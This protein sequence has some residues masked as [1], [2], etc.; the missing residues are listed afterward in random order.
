MSLNAQSNTQVGLLPM[1]AAADLTGKEGLLATI[2][3]TGVN[4][5][6]NIAD[7][8]PY[9][10]EEGAASGANATVRP[11]TAEKNH[12]VVAKG[13]GSRGDVLVLA[14]IAGSDAGK[15]RAIPTANGT[16]HTVALAEENFVDGQL[17][18]VR[19]ISRETIVIN[20]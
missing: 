1:Q 15:V 8:T 7:R 2:Q 6:A 9:L 19:P 3:S 16:Y 18:L 12:R 4:L 11:F 17:V 10:I 13:S 14:A 5:P 20:N